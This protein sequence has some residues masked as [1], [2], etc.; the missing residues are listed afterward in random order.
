MFNECGTIPANVEVVLCVTEMHIPLLLRGLRSDIAV[1][2]QNC[3]VN[4]SNG[5][6]TWVILGHSERREGFGGDPGESVGL[7]AAK[8]KA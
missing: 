8:C 6:Y 7:C 5:G 3:G 4:T 1:G 2:G